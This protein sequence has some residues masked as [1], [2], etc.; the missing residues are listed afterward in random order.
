MNFSVFRILR[1]KL[2]EKK[3]LMKYI[4]NEDKLL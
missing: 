2:S 3:G 4:F 1:V